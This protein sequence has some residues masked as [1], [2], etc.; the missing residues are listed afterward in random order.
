MT[1]TLSNKILMAPLTRCM[2]DD[3]LVPTQQIADYYARRAEAGLIISE[4]T[5]IRADGQGLSK[6]SGFY[7]PLRKLMAGV[8]LQTLY[9][10][11]AAKYLPSHNTPAAW[12]THTFLAV[13]TYYRLLPKRLKAQCQ[14]CVN[15]FTKPQKPP[16]LKTLNNW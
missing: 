9:T 7:L 3:D 14:E 8:W 11:M 12:L 10:K 16:Q 13:V 4:A 2:A 5:I 1:L 15:W 6:H